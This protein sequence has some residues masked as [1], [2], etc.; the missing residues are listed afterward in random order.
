MLPWQPGH[1]VVF[2][3]WRYH[4]EQ[5]PNTSR[6]ATAHPQGQGREAYQDNQ[7]AQGLNTGQP[8]PMT[9]QGRG[10]PL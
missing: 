10:V 7:P 9:G 1:Q 6:P 3:N 5:P 4:I 8:G 2:D